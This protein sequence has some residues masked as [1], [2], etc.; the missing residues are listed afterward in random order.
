VFLCLPKTRLVES[1]RLATAFGRRVRGAR[2]VERNGADS[3][4]IASG[5]RRPR[6]HRRLFRRAAVRLSGREL[7]SL[8]QAA[9]RSY[10]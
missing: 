5:R 8:G 1:K 10:R 3:F 4:F 7:G 9:C 6:R 2:S